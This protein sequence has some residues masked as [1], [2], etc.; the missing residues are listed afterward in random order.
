M[1]SRLRKYL[2]LLANPRYWRALSQGVAATVEHD[3]ALGADEFATVI[4]VGANK[5][6]FATYAL[7][8]WPQARLIC[9]SVN[10]PA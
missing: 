3:A 9:F 6:Q 5:G 2:K 7:T 10:Q 1:R 4:D 8:R